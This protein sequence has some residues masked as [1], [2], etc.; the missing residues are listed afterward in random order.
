MNNKVKTNE[1]GQRVNKQG[2]PI[3]DPVGHRG[4]KKKDPPEFKF[5]PCFWCGQEFGSHS[6]SCLVK[7]GED[8]LATQSLRR[9]K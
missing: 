3:L 6:R 2:I 9:K 4:H 7:M 5:E 8:A 1:L